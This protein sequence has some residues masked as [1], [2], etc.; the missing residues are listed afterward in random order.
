MFCL[1]LAL[2][3]RPSF[4][5][6]CVH[7]RQR[8][9]K[10][11]KELQRFVQ[12]TESDP[13][14]FL[15]KFLFSSFFIAFIRSLS[16]LF[17]SMRTKKNIPITNFIKKRMFFAHG[18]AHTVCLKQNALG[19][20]TVHSLLLCGLLCSIRTSA[21]SLTILADFAHQLVERL[22]DIDASLS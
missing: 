13:S 18:H 8:L 1:D 6:C 11:L 17:T 4:V 5:S 3:C 12:S 10:P 14:F 2:P 22:F 15:T 20:Q 19:Q 21:R 9:Q 7:Q 16:F